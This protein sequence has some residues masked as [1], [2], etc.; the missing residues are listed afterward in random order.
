MARRAALSGFFG[1]VIEY[2][3]FL[4]YGSAA[5]LVFGPLFFPS[6]TPATGTLA[7]FAT[8]GVAY[9]ARPLGAVIFG[10]FGDLIGRKRVLM[11]TLVVMGLSSVLI[12]LLPTY[13]SIGVAAPIILVACRIAQGISAGGE[14]TGAS[15]LTM[16]HASSGRRTFY[17][18]WTPNG[19]AV[20]S[21]L[22][23]A[24][25]IPISALPE[26]ALMSW[27]W[28]IPFLISV[29]TLPIALYLRS[30]VDESP[31][32][33]GAKAKAKA[34]AKKARTPLKRVLRDHPQAVFCVM[35][36]ALLQSVSS[37]Q[38]VF[39]VSF[40]ARDGAV[41]STTLL[42]AITASQAFSVVFIPFWARMADRLGLKRVFVT[43]GIGCAIACVVFIGAVAEG[44]VWL[45]VVSAILLKG[46]IYSA[47]YGIW[48]VFYGRQFSSDVRYTGTGLSMQISYL[49]MGF[50]P[51][52]C[53][54]L[55]G[56]GTSGWWIAGA[57]MAGLCLA[58]AAAGA[59]SRT[60]ME[61]AADS[62]APKS[63]EARK[64]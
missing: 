31:E 33:T 24:V 55:V 62:T 57:F 13:E 3:D 59:L 41:G 21:A 60:A 51:A 19:A 54:A 30:G 15:L 46:V 1:S 47:P 36:C 6:T 32:F 25:F 7:A 37:F 17:S 35:V 23:T 56:E 48:P 53:V 64:A 11:I 16:E 50:V 61:P 26:D 34:A 14:Q 40:A 38:Q 18:S 12:G 4:I 29:I 43:G 10:H 58:S 2:Y 9:I 39:G 20:G 45:A 42:A 22:A 27:G 8:F 63:P 5:A 28:R 44:N 49:V 52:I